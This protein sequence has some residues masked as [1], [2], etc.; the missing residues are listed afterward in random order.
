[1]VGQLRKY[2]E[3]LPDNSTMPKQ[4]ILDICD[5]TEE[6]QRKIAQI[7]NEAQ[8]MQQRAMSFLDSDPDEQSDAILQAQEELSGETL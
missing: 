4:K 5:K 7:N 2:A 6:E 1:M 8:M 3:S